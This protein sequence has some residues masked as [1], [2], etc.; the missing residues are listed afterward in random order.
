MVV[1]A[2]SPDKIEASSTLAR[3]VIEPSIRKAIDDFLA[4][5]DAITIEDLRSAAIVAR[6]LEAEAP[7]EPAADKLGVANDK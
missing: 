7:N 4:N 1:A 6:V 5:L 2:D 3:K